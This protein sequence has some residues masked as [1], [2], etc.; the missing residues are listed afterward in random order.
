M[1]L[2]KLQVATIKINEIPFYIYIYIYIY[3]PS[4]N[5]HLKLLISANQI[6]SFFKMHFLTAFTEHLG[7]FK[8]LNFHTIFFKITTFSKSTI[9]KN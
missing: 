8:K 9:S 3:I 6:F 4:D 7:F 1:T 2:K 5:L